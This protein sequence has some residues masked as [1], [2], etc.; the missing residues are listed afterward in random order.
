M[1]D[2]VITDNSELSV[3][4][5]TI[6]SRRAAGLVYNKVGNRVVLMATSVL[7]EFRGEE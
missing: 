4:E 3:Y 5:A 2:I 1:E 7:P 6:G